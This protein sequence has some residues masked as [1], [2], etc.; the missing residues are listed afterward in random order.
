MVPANGDVPPANGELGNGPESDVSEFFSHSTFA[1]GELSISTSATNSP[2]N[3]VPS[4]PN[5]IPSRV[6]KS[7]LV[8]LDV[9][10]LIAESIRRTHNGESIS[11]L[12]GEWAQD[13]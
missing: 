11:M 2:E 9:S 5:L 4:S 8:I 3:S 7:K 10:N 1:N 12:F 6:M 13:K